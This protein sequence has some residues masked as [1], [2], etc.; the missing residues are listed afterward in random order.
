MERS[1][2]GGKVEGS[3]SEVVHRLLG[4]PK[5]RGRQ[6]IDGADHLTSPIGVSVI[7]RHLIASKRVNI[8]VQSDVR[9]TDLVR[10][11]VGQSLNARLRKCRL[12]LEAG[13][14][15]VSLEEGIEE[16]ASKK[17]PQKSVLKSPRESSCSETEVGREVP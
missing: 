8:R 1:F 16:Y 12:S 3:R 11:E 2:R 15:K 4:R 7:E 14:P 10:Q 17:R 13:E 6:R 9:Q 5:L